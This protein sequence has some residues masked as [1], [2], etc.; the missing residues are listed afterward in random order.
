MESAMKE[1]SKTISEAATTSTLTESCVQMENE[2]LSNDIP[3]KSTIENGGVSDSLKLPPVELSPKEDTKNRLEAVT[4]SAPVK[5]CVQME[6]E[7]LSNDVPVESTIKNAYAFD[8]PKPPPIESAIKE[9][10]KSSSEDVTTSAPVESYVQMENE[11]LS[12]EI[13][14][15][16]TIETVAASDSL[17]LPPVELPPKEDSKT[18]SEVVTMSA[19][20]EAC[21]QMENE[22][23]SNESPVRSTIET[24]SAFDSPKP[25]PL[26]LAMKDD[27]KIISEPVI[28]SNHTELYVQMANEKL[29][30]DIPVKSTIENAAASDSPKLPPDESIPTE[31]STTKSVTDEEEEDISF[32]KEASFLVDK[33]IIEDCAIAQN[34]S[35]VECAAKVAALHALS[36]NRV[37]ALGDVKHKD[38]H[39]K[40]MGDSIT[41]VEDDLASP[42]LASDDYDCNFEYLSPVAKRLIESDDFATPKQHNPKLH[43]EPDDFATPKQHNVTISSHS[44][45][46]NSKVVTYSSETCPCFSE[47]AASSV[48]ATT[49]QHR[50]RFSDPLGLLTQPEQS[51]ATSSEDDSEDEDSIGAMNRPAKLDFVVPGFIIGNDESNDSWLDQSLFSST[52]NNLS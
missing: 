45:K 27:S 49:N 26:E 14:V 13:S 7:N 43:I 1:D 46:D 33:D 39:T 23:F 2:D 29:S 18:S 15:K 24:V 51:V 38:T 22:A 3:V 50:E 52:L 21:A 44:R 34:Q 25:P 37:E 40:P 19:P 48:A 6:N 16:S 35:L 10:T 28:T 9:D 4:T 32:E 47:L 30:N 12:N 20:F 31:D 11:N 5:S 42:K 8:S 41:N 17:K 36:M